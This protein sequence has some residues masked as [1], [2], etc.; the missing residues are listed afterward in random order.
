V[1]MSGWLPFKGQIEGSMDEERELGERKERS[2]KYLENESGKSGGVARGKRIGILSRIWKFFLRWISGAAWLFIWLLR[3][4]S[5]KALADSHSQSTTQKRRRAV[6]YI[7]T[8]LSL[9]SQDLDIDSK[10]PIFLGHGMA[11]QK[12][13]YEWGLQMQ[14]ALKEMG[15]NFQS[16]SYEKV[17]HWYCEE[18][19]RDL[20]SFLTGLWRLK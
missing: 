12:V 8:L 20:I 15:L 11:D 10:M 9:P 17:E 16:R 5:I 14:Y 6:Q 4:R 13:K 3:R 7:R 18:E 1:G 2:V 19:M